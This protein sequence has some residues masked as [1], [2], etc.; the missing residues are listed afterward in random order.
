MKHLWAALLTAGTITTARHAHADD[1]RRARERLPMVVED[2]SLPLPP[3][4]PEFVNRTR[5]RWVWDHVVAGRVNPLGAVTRVRT[6]YRV[7]LTNR[8]GPLFDE[9]MVALKMVGEI[10]PAY[11]A[12]GG[13]FE[14]QPLTILQLAVQQE[15][16]G[17]HAAFFTTMSY[18]TTDADYRDSTMRG[19]RDDAYSTIGQSTALDA[20]FQVKLETIALRSQFRAVTQRMRLREGDRLFYSQPYD[21]LFPNGGWMIMNDLDLLWLFPFGLKIGARYTATR[22]FYG[23]EADPNGTGAAL[24]P[25]HRVG[26]AIAYTFFERKKDE[27]SRWN[28]PTLALLAQ[29][30]ARHPY[31][32]GEGSSAAL[33]YLLLAFTHRGDFLP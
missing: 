21:V 26:P 8:A 27:G 11:S 16:I 9:S 32:T 19:Q 13:R 20:L 18:P 2:L 31:R 14:L 33:P 3:A 15:V 25:T 5:H 7:Q 23:E 12:V 1:D 28:A 17:T 22:V 10:T 29:W 4:E 24:T 30:W 6:G